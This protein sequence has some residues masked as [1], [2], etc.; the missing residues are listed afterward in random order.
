M[1]D[2]AGIRCDGTHP[3]FESEAEC[4]TKPRTAEYITQWQDGAVKVLD[5]HVM[6][7]PEG[8]TYR[9]LFL[10]RSRRQQT[11]SQLKFMRLIGALTGN[12]DD[13]QIAEYERRLQEDEAAA[14]KAITGQIGSVLKIRFEDLVA[15]TESAADR[16]ACWLKLTPEQKAA[17]IAQVRPRSVSVYPGMLEIQMIEE[18]EAKKQE[19][20]TP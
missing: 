4:A 19:G 3:T 14:L 17:M 7:L 13:H 8:F 10:T 15:R 18:R 11:L 6:T 16:I 9:F 12:I 20:E 1:L 2:A 5:P